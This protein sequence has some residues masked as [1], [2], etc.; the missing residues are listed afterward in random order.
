MES[1]FPY[2]EGGKTQ[3]DSEETWPEAWPMIATMAV[4][5]E[6]LRFC[7]AVHILPLRHPLTVAKVTSTVDALAPGR[8]VLGVG[9]GWM[10]EEY[11]AFGV[12]F[13]TRGR[14]MDECIEVVR[15]VWSGEMVE[16]HGEFFDFDRLLM[17]PAPRMPIPIWIGGASAGALRR[18]ARVG[19]GW[20]GGGE[21]SAALIASL[22]TLERLR[23]EAGRSHCPFE[24]ITLH[25]VGLTHDFE[26]LDRLEDA[27]LSG[28]VHIPFK[29]GL[30]CE[31]SPLDQK[32][33]YLEKFAAE[34][35]TRDG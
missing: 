11:R 18:A 7:S 32:R 15:A 26:E 17:R 12:D 20:V 24:T 28:I 30:G 5:T 21:S 13:H 2:G 33:A 23:T 10:E 8:V 34:V 19:D 1:H 14:R 22:Q 31:T 3:F 16:H 9:A 4:G 6:R 25:P 29:F 35:I 27:G